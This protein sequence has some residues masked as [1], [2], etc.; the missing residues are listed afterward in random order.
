MNTLRW[1][2]FDGF[3]RCDPLSAGS[4]PSGKR[5]FSRP[6]TSAAQLSAASFSLTSDRVFPRRVSPSQVSEGRLSE[7]SLRTPRVPPMRFISL[8]GIMCRTVPRTIGFPRV[9][10]HRRFRPRH[11]FLDSTV[12]W[13]SRVRFIPSCVVSSSESVRR[14]SR[15]ALAAPCLGVSSLFAVLPEESTV[16][17]ASHFPLCSVRRFSQPL[18][19]LLRL[20]FCGLVSSRNHVQGFRS[21]AWSRT[22]AVPARRRPVPP[23]PFRAPAHRLPGCHIHT[24][25]FEALIR[26]AMRSS[27]SV[28]GLRRRRSPLRCCLLQVPASGSRVHAMTTQPLRS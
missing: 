7:A 17:G 3:H 15:A 20:R 11:R 10:H 19:G 25:S 14:P 21:G 22:A 5:D 4:G 24:L 1:L 27:K 23:C 2:T 26:G 12:P 9:R 6:E 16:R 8:Q 18:D 13:P 28:V